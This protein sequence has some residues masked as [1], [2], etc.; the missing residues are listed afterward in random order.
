[1]YRDLQDYYLH[2]YHQ[3]PVGIDG[4][5]QEELRRLHRVLYTAIEYFVG[6]YASFVQD[7]GFSEK[8]WELLEKQALRPFRAGTYRPDY[9]L[10]M[11]RDLLLCEITSRFFAHGIFMSWFGEQAARAF[12]ERFPSE[13][14]H[15]DF[16]PMMDYMLSLAGGKKRMYVLKSADKTNEI[17]LYNTNPRLLG[18]DPIKALQEDAGGRDAMIEVYTNIRETMRRNAVE[19]EMVEGEDYEFRFD[20]GIDNYLEDN[21]DYNEE[22]V[23]DNPEVEISSEP[24]IG[25]IRFVFSS[26]GYNEPEEE[27][28]NI[29]DYETN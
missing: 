28:I 14:F 18:T 4:R 7:W 11:E 15:S 5:R 19:G 1:M 25:K 3:R 29:S 16:G 8:E 9:I 20:P 2:W 21:G 23:R 22:R 10:S 6:H 27:D 12:M 24:D 13:P 17:R 26:D